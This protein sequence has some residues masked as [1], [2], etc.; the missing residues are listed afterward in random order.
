MSPAW[1]VRGAADGSA[2][3]KAEREGASLADAAPHGKAAAMLLHDGLDDRQP[4][5]AAAVVRVGRAPA[6]MKAIEDPG[7]LVGR[8]PG[9]GVRYL[10]D[11]RVGKH[12]QTDRDLPAG[13]RIS[14]RIAEQI[15]H[16]L[17]QR[18]GMAPG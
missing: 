5:P 7:D 8:D 11:H 14:Q 16:R 12:S 1:S 2:T 17:L 10:D 18:R 15:G 4:Q 9:A 6:A 3:W 13:G